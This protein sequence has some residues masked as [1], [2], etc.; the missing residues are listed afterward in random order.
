MR[1]RLGS[2]LIAGLVWTALGCGGRGPKP[3]YEGPKVAPFSG[4]VV[5]DGEPVTFP[6][7]EEVRVH[8][9]VIE[10]EGIGKSFGVPIK[11][12]GAF[13]IRWMP[14]G[15]MTLRLERSPKDPAKTKGGPPNRY[16]IPG[17]LTIE[18]GKTTGYIIELGKGWKR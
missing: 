4:Q 16:S 10:G 15:K 9:T 18:Q 13:S 6:E 7:D 12:D 5:Q 3:Y 1:V 2:A 8:C 14:V 17:G 11:P